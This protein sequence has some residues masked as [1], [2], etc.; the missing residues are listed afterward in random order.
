[1]R[2]RLERRAKA[3][4]MAMAM[5]MAMAN[6]LSKRHFGLVDFASV[7]AV[8]VGKRAQHD[9]IL[10]PCVKSTLLLDPRALLDPPAHQ[11]EAQ[12]QKYFAIDCSRL[13]A[14][15]TTGINGK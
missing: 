13:C 15:R 8:C 11:R 5:A 6:H 9:A 3:K 1:M 12:R 10:Q 7:R 4:G 14:V 2:V